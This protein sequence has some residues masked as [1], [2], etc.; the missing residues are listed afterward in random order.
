[1]RI[2]H[3]VVVHSL[4]RAGSV[5]AQHTQSQR[6]SDRFH[7]MCLGISSHWQQVIWPTA[8]ELPTN[9]KPP[10]RMESCSA[11]CKQRCLSRAVVENAATG[12]LCAGVLQPTELRQKGQAEVTSHTA[13]KASALPTPTHLI[14]RKRSGLLE[15]VY[16]Q[17]FTDTH[18]HT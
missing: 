9:M 3:K 6:N 15:K 14:Y 17:I 5:K 12:Q 13:G 8:S 1:M 2:S 7:C 16:V 4:S 11:L 18:T 10:Q